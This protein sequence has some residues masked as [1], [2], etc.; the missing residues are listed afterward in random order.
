MWKVKCKVVPMVIG[1]L[2][3]VTPKLKEWLQ[4]IPGTKSEVSVKK[5]AALGTAKILNQKPR[6][7]RVY[8]RKYDTNQTNWLLLRLV[9]I[10]LKLRY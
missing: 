4:Q 3:A 5:S 9:C 6:S 10:F 2:W 1:T 7:L 8:L